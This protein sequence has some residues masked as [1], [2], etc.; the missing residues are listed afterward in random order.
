MNSNTDP[1]S[2]TNFDSLSDGGRPH[3]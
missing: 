2:I 3:L 1:N